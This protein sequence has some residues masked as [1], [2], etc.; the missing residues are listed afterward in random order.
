MANMEHTTQRR[1]DNA[2]INLTNSVISIPELFDDFT[3]HRKVQQMVCSHCKE[4]IIPVKHDESNDIRSFHFNIFRNFSTKEIPL[5]Y[6][7][8]VPEK[9]IYQEQTTF[10]IGLTNNFT[11]TTLCAMTWWDQ[12][13]SSCD[14]N[15]EFPITYEGSEHSMLS[16]V[17]S[18]DSSDNWLF[19]STLEDKKIRHAYQSKSNFSLQNYKI[20]FVSMHT[21]AET[22][23]VSSLN[24]SMQEVNIGDIIITTHSPERVQRCSGHMPY[25]QFLPECLDTSP[26][27]RYEKSSPYSSKHNYQINGEAGTL[28]QRSEH[29]KEVFVYNIR[30]IYGI[31]M[32]KIDLVGRSGKIHLLTNNRQTLE[33]IQ[34]APNINSAQFDVYLNPLTDFQSNS[35]AVFQIS[36]SCPM[37]SILV[38][39]SN[40]S[41][42]TK[43][44]E[45]PKIMMVLDQ[46][47]ALLGYMS[48]RYED[49]TAVKIEG[50]IKV[51]NAKTSLKESKCENMQ[52]TSISVVIIVSIIM[53]FIIALSLT[54]FARRIK[55]DNRKMLFMINATISHHAD[56]EYSNAREKSSKEHEG[57]EHQIVFESVQENVY[58]DE[59]ELYT[60]PRII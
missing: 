27:C 56:K 23:Y 38:I 30:S 33:E 25:C 29:Q 60:P 10:R 22:V 53:I 32:I 35:S 59:C 39:F 31:R 24:R 54:L 36:N 18:I 4:K 11:S 3:S 1:C 42:C 49:I 6:F 8:V 9:Q 7:G 13:P 58:Y 2:T 5:I 28:K 14:A 37:F 47:V 40:G 20:S 44:I 34:I 19:F 17:I 46:K 50:D 15:F 48:E 21:F 43:D 55:R 16:Y 12:K 45:P 26:S 52:S 51:L 57:R 41:S